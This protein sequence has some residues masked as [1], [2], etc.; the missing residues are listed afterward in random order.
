MGAEHHTNIKKLFLLYVL[1]GVGIT[2]LLSLYVEAQ[3]VR[4]LYV[5][6][7]HYNP[8]Y[9]WKVR[10]LLGLVLLV[11]PLIFIAILVLVAFLFARRMVRWYGP[12]LRELR[13]AV[14]KIKQQDLN[15]SITYDAPDEL[16][17]LCRTVN[18]LHS[19]LQTSL[20]REWTR[21]EEAR[22][23]V[24]ALSHD[25]RTPVAILQGHIES[26]ANAQPEKRALR[27]ERYLPALEGNIQRLTRLLN[28]IMMISSLEQ[29]GFVLRPRLINLEHELNR[30]A[31]AY[32]LR[33]AEHN[34]SFHL[35]AYKL[36]EMDGE[37]ELDIHRIEQ[38][39]DNLFENALR[40]TPSG[41]AITLTW[42]WNRNV[43]SFSMSDTGPGIATQDLPHIFEKYYSSSGRASGSKK[44]MG[45]GLYVC[46]T[47][48]EHY[49]GSI[50]ACNLPKG[51]GEISFW[52]ALDHTC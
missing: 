39:L 18:E 37:I 26:L 27:L 4:H 38:I 43:I 35:L 51:G 30:K 1:S 16:G 8:A 42:A 9:E 31:E 12:P 6:I 33:C 40:F 5:M 29:S 19:Q 34:I 47:L 49:G 36:P 45:L 15:F 23:M 10:L 46:K 13:E 21:E 24:A 52:I 44:P 14:E 17:D 28:D 50:A 7:H 11:P 48:V 41:G 20:L 32:T 2:A 3:L 25:L 22:E